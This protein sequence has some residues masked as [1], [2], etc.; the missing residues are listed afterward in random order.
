MPSTKNTARIASLL[1][2]LAAAIGGFGYNYIRMKV[3]VAGDAVATAHNVLSSTSAFR[4]AIFVTLVAQVLIFFFGLM[5]FRVL[6]Q[7]SQPWAIL[8]L[9]SVLVSVTLAIMN[10]LSNFGAL[11]VLTEPETLGAFSET[12]LQTLATILLRLSGI[13]QGLLEI[14]W[15]PYYFAL[16]YLAIKYRFVPR[17]LGVLLL[18]MAAGFWINLVDKFL[19]PE[20]H[21]LLFTRLA[22][23]FGALGGLPFMLWLLIKGARVE[24]T[25]PG[26][27][28][29]A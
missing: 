26:A 27:T 6:R 4:A 14:F 25:Q 20:F 22:M 2:L 16:A 28:T 24:T 3:F 1:F 8:F 12:Q 18:L 11:F 17:V 13:G 5:L 7:I 9:T 21:P 29:T 10:Q 23:S 15:T 19:F